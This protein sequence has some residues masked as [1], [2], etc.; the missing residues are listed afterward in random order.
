MINVS[1]ID[2]ISSESLAS[3]FQAER[4]NQRGSFQRPNESTG[5]KT[6][7]LGSDAKD[8]GDRDHHRRRGGGRPGQVSDRIR[9]GL[10]RP[11]RVDPIRPEAGPE[12]IRHRKHG[13]QPVQEFQ[14]LRRVQDP[15]QVRPVARAR[16]HSSEQ[17]RRKPLRRTR[18]R[19]PGRRKWKAQRISSR[20]RIRGCQEG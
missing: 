19:W 1:N 17:Q 16:T 5:S 12:E 3:L 8:R 4:H 18:I 11:G 20:R 2:N 15:V 7:Q 10:H 9:R 13:G 14:D 6:E